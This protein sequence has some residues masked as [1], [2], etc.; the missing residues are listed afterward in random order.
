MLKKSLPFYIIILIWPVL[1]FAVFYIGVNFNSFLL[2][3]QNIDTY[4]NV[5]TFTFDNITNA[6]NLITTDPAMRE[7]IINSLIS[8]GLSLV[9]GIP[10]GLLFAYY[11]FKKWPL[12]GSFRVILFLPSIL[13]V[14]VSVTIYMYFV[15][16]ALEFVLKEYFGK[17]TPLGFLSNPD[18]RFGAVLFFAIFT[19]FG[20]SVLMYTNKMNSIDPEILEAG[21]LDGA[22]GF[23]EF[24]YIVLPLTYPTLTIFLYT[25]IITIFTS[26]LNL[27]SF[28][29]SRSSI[30]TIGYFLYVS[31][32]RAQGNVSLYPAVAAYGLIF[33]CVAVP[34]TFIVKFLLEKFG[35]SE[36]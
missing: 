17:T 15:E 33:T 21:K 6:F 36:D 19:G 23:K 35:P 4:N 31:T 29:S 18:T 34:L 16:N 3:F 10:L 11:I 26:Q 20:T 25:G 27:Y 32:Q 1:Q 22:S 14:I 5:T 13:P 7:T 9:N 28:Y 24:W 30:Q 12:A 2:A 8:Y